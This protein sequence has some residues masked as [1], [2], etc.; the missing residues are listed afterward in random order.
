MTT[1]TAIEILSDVTSPNDDTSWFVPAE[2]YDALSAQ[3]Q[4]SIDDYL[5]S[6]V[7]PFMADYGY[8]PLTDEGNR[9][10]AD[11]LRD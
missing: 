8:Y 2:R 5:E 6:P 9:L 11:W 3:Q 7:W 1:T 4:A 10:M